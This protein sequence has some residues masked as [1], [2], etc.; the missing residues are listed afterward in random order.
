MVL[1]SYQSS[2]IRRIKGFCTFFCIMFY[3]CSPCYLG[4][5]IDMLERASLCEKTVRTVDNNLGTLKHPLKMCNCLTFNLYICGYIFNKQQF[6]KI[7][8][9]SFYL[10][11]WLL[12]RW[13][14]SDCEVSASG[15]NLSGFYLQEIFYRWGKKNL[16]YKILDYKE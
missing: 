11:V 13:L 7:L 8:L 10:V 2:A 5:T 14:K 3:Q 9:K 6:G 12:L 16:N 1:S 15:E 4:Y